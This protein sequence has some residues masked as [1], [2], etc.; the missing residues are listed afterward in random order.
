MDVIN[1]D[2]KGIIE[3]HDVIR[4]FI[5]ANQFIYG[6]FNLN[7]FTLN[8]LSFCLWSTATSLDVLAFKYVTITYSLMLIIVTV[9]VMKFCNPWVIRKFLP[10]V[11]TKRSIKTSIIHGLVAF[12]VI[13]YSQSTK[14]S[15][16]L[17]TPGHIHWIGSTR[18][19]K[20]SRVVYLNGDVPFMGTEHLRYAIPAIFFTV[21]FTII[22]PFLLIVYPLCYKLFALLRIQETLCIHILCSVVPLEKL[23]PLFDSFQSCFN[24][25]HRYFAGLYFIYRLS[26]LICYAVTDSLTLFYSLI[27]VQLIL[28][29]ILHAV[30]QPYKKK[31]HNV[32]DI[33]L[34]GLLAVIN[35]MT[36]YNYQMAY[37]DHKR[38][39]HRI[40]FVSTCQIFLAF[41]P[42]VCILVYCIK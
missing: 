38:H 37:R 19:H 33:L 24:D 5:K 26:A 20:V 10:C 17:L 23:K 28:S 35:V 22:P 13:C 8:K 32:I 31:W 34:L 12:L 16:S 11:R 21:T 40:Y 39:Q 15:L 14:V 6:V 42:L 41:L 4:L 29:L 1:I 18:N 9:A 27:E 3:T 36:M 7:F 25:N 30:I 2:V